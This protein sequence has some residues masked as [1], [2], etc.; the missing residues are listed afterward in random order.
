MSI[1]KIGVLHGAILNGGDYLICKRGTRLLDEYLDSKFELVHIKRWE[2]FEGDFDALIILGGPIVARAMQRQ[3]INI[4]EYLINKEMPVIALGIGISGED[5][6]SLSDYFTDESLEFWKKIYDV[7]NLISVRDKITDEVFNHVN[8]GSRL[9]GCP[10]LFDLDNIDKMDKLSDNAVREKKKI[11]FTIPNIFLSTSPQSILFNVVHFKNFLLSLFFITYMKITFKLGKIDAEYVLV[12]QHG[13]NTLIRL[14]SF[15][16]KILGIRSVDASK[17]SLDDVEEIKSS[18]MHIGSR[19]HAHILFLSSRRPSYLFNVDN[20]TKAFLDTLDNDYN[21][22]FSFMGIIKLVKLASK[23]LKDSEKI[24]TRFMKSNKKISEYFKEMHS[25][26]TD[27][28]RF[29][30]M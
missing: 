9:T 24:N 14:V 5:Y 10:A 7:S 30:Q 17:R 11:S 21:V 26:L 2:S 15:Y 22:N 3:P 6:D 1:E 27:L 12:M 20:R 25:F 19:L 29:L 13:F 23:E 8:I 18:N 4:R 28:D 16:C